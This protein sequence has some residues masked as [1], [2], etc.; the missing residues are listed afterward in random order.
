MDSQLS[1]QG[2]I[3]L[4]TGASTGIGFEIAKVLCKR[5]IGVVLVAR[6][7]EKLQAAV[8]ELIRQFPSVMVRMIAADL[9]LDSAAE[10]IFSELT[11]LQISPEILVNNA[12]F[13][14][15]G[16]FSGSESV[17][18]KAMID[19]NISALVLLS[20]KFL[21]I[22]VPR[23]SGMILNT[24]STAA[25]QPGPGM[26]VYSATKSFVLSFSEALH[27]ELLG[28]GVSVT[29]LCPGPTIT[30]FIE[31]AGMHTSRL[32]NG[33]GVLSAEKVAHVGV[34]A[35]FQRKRRVIPGMINNV[36]VFFSWLFPKTIILKVTKILLRN[37]SH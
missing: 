33:P 12:G 1:L 9:A 30:P 37:P 19:T 27:E 8:T 2:N 6:N 5:G 31:R 14:T 4:V 32:F 13:A 35:M 28:S 34:T 21:E 36:T 25:F 20:H 16:D 15:Y 18:E 26:A 10:T 24:A 22:A 3:A 11:K 23:K 17:Q 29:A 7:V